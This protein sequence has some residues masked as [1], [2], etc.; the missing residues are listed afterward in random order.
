MWCVRR[1]A[2]ALRHTQKEKLDLLGHLLLVDAELLVNVA[3]ATDAATPLVA[4]PKAHG[5]HMG[6]WTEY[7]RR[8]GVCVRACVF[9]PA[10]GKHSAAGVCSKRLKSHE[11]RRGIGVV[12]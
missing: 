8:V 4:R 9:A 2:G 12:D 3:G 10:G 11:R 6:I 5:R 1:L 7:R